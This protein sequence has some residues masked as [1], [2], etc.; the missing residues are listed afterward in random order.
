MWIKEWGGTTWIMP[1]PLPQ[2]LCEGL[3]KRFRTCGHEYLPPNKR[4]PL[5]I[6]G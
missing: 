1:P 6:E 2:Q 5:P 3:A 4:Y